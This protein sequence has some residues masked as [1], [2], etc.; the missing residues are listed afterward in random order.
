M[1]GSSAGKSESTSRNQQQQSSESSGFNMGQSGSFIDPTQSPFLANLFQQGSDLAGQ[2]MGAGSQFQNQV[3]NPAM[4]AFQN[5]LTPQQNPFLQGQIEQGQGLINENLQQNILPATGG[6]AVGAGQFGGGRQGVAEGIAM[7]DANR[8]STD[9]AQNLIGQ[10]FQG[11]QQRAIQALS[12]AGNISGLQFSPLQNLREL[13]GSSTVLNQASNFGQT[14]SRS[15][16]S[17]LGQSDSK[18]SQLGF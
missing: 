15:S 6:A 14:Q 1:A 13:L 7:R 8:A 17:S 9:F 3:A 10:D 2:Q 5:F 16:G 12:Q 4:N 18:S 11:Q